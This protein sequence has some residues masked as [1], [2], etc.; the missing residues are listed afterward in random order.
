M[1]LCIDHLNLN[2]IAGSGQCFRWKETKDN[3]YL[4]P[5]VRINNCL[6]EPLKITSLGESRFDLSCSEAE[7]QNIWSVYFDISSDY[8][9]IE[10]LI[11]SSKDS[12]CI[13]AFRQGY[14]IRILR[15]DLWEVIISFLI[16]QNNNISRITRSIEAICQKASLPNNAFPYPGEIDTCIFDD[17]SLG[18]GYRNI[19]LKKIYDFA[20]QN[21]EFTDELKSMTY[22]KAYTTLLSFTGIGPKVANCICLFGLHHVDAFPID[23]HVKQLL[24]KYYPKGFPFDYYEGIAGIVQQYLFYYELNN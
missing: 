18:L 1:I 24:T 17:T 11:L 9:H 6:S 19:Y 14:G 3:S 20:A 4:I 12:H 16:S 22:E 10:K 15:Q 21:P 13:D 2:Q 5:P 23:T 8:G 7:W